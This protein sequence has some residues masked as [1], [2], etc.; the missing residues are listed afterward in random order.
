MDVVISKS[1]RA[2]KRMQAKFESKTIHFGQ[3]GGQA[4]VDH[5]NQTKKNAWLARHKVRGNFE[6][7]QT[8][9]GLAKNILW[10]KTNM[11]A[12]IKNLNARQ[13]KYNFKLVPP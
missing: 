5:Q 12:S 2:E 1:P 13:S 3:S 11:K 7:L 4:F 9:S 6:N 8:A 10:N